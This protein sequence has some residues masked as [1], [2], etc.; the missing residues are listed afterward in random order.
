M[1]K[2]TAEAPKARGGQKGVPRGNAVIDL[3]LDSAVAGD[4]LAAAT[5]RRSKWNEQLDALYAATEANKV[6]RGEDG[7]LKFVRVGHFSNANGAR[8]QARAL[9]K[10]GRDA[11]FE[12]RHAADGKGSDLW[13]RVREVAE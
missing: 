3:D 10:K 5:V 6:P 4:S 9:E 7:Q 2:E 8:T 13:A 1:A 12:F 11:T